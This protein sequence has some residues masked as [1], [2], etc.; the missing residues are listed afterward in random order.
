M[1][2]IQTNVSHSKRLA[3][4]TWHTP[5]EENTV[6]L[7]SQHA[8]FVRKAVGR[9]PTRRKHSC[10]TS[11]NSMQR[12]MQGQSC[13]FF[14]LLL[15]SNTETCNWFVLIIKLSPFCLFFAQLFLIGL[16]CV[17]PLSVGLS[18]LTLRLVLA[19]V[20]LTYLGFW[21]IS[22]FSYGFF[23][24]CIIHFFFYL[25]WLC[26][27][28]GLSNTFWTF[29]LFFRMSGCSTGLNHFWKPA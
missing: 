9:P 27:L 10:N 11:D 4:F 19:L 12:H 8:V 22:G 13:L 1:R 2:T 6:S 16:L 24:G 14:H 25:G 20:D 23:T 3:H 5:K 18:I 7:L 26:F 28:F 21:T 17:D 29:C 15:M